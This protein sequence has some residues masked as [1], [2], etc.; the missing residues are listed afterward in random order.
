MPSIAQML[1]GMTTFTL[2]GDRYVVVAI[3]HLV[4]A[5]FMFGISG[6]LRILTPVYEP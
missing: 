4:N 1:D 3:W 2:A 6:K 5:D